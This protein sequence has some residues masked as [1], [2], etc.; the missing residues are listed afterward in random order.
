MI[1]ELLLVGCGGFL[2]ACGRFLVGKVCALLCHSAFPLGTFAVNIAGC[3]L[4][5]V[6]MGLS[7][8][9]RAFTAE[10]NLMLVTGLCG[11]F[12][13]FSTFANDMWGLADRGNWCVLALYLGGSVALGML[14][15]CLGRALVR[16]I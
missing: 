4:I 11:G 13:T 3:L 8:R 7:E 16:Y 5:G 2:G 10:E 12:T 14:M 9:S 15:V 6:F 1:K